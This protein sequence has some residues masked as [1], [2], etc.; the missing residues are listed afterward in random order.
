MRLVRSS[1]SL[2]LVWHSPS[3]RIH[4][5]RSIRPYLGRIEQETCCRLPSRCTDAF[6]NTLSPPLPRAPYQR[7]AYCRSISQ[8]E[9]QP[10]TQTG[11]Q[12]NLQGRCA[13]H[14]HGQKTTFPQCQNHTRTSRW[15]HAI[16]SPPRGSPFQL[17][18]KPTLPKR[19]DARFQN[20]LLRNGS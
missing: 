3:N 8:T 19:D 2:T 1:I 13:S 4:R 10:C 9:T 17:H 16:F 12:R 7:G 20:V 15:Q 18:G 5:G 14:C 6:I 11:P